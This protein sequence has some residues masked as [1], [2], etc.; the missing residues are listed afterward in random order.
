M[1]SV[2]VKDLTLNFGSISVLKSLNI[3]VADGE[4][5]VLLGPVGLRQVHSA[6]LHRRPA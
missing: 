5:L 2:S 3:D 6:Q 1:T 4:F